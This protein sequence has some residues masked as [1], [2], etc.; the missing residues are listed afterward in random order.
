[1]Q[2]FSKS[3]SMFIYIKLMYTCIQFNLCCPRSNSL[4]V[5]N[6]TI[7]LKKKKQQKKTA[8]K[9]LVCKV[10]GVIRKKYSSTIFLASILEL[11]T[12]Y[13]VSFVPFSTS[14]S[15]SYNG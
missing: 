8:F 12:A 6:T 13:P 3:R 15:K 4:I 9:C 5:K 2:P 7:R 14:T 10:T 1:M 11:A